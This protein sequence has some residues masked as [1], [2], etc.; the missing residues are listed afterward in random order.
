MQI[1]LE[2]QRTD[3]ATFGASVYGNPQTEI[4]V[5]NRAFWFSTFKCHRRFACV[6]F[7]IFSKSIREDKHSRENQETP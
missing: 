7:L 5:N 1:N 6:F 3:T 2:V 4:V